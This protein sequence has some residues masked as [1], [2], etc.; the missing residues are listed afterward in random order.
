MSAFLPRSHKA[1]RRE[2]RR[3]WSWRL[4]EIL[5][6]RLEA[7]EFRV[8]PGCLLVAN[9]VSWLDVLVLSALCPAD[10]VAKAE[11]R[12]WPLLGRLLE[13]HDCLF[14]DRRV[15][16]HLLALNV[17][18]AARLA[19]GRVVALF[20]EATTTG[21]ASLLPFRPALF[22]PAVRG[23]HP[24]LAVSL[25]YSD[26]SGRR[27]EAAAFI[28]QQSLWQSL[29]A[30]AVQSAITVQVRDAPP[31]AAAAL[32]RRDAARLAQAAIQDRLR[33]GSS[34]PAPQYPAATPDGAA[35]SA[36]AQGIAPSS[37]API[38]AN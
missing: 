8:P 38:W 15:G 34:L 31:I 22:E 18:I 2:F 20:P 6:I 21:G 29:R 1:R 32:S 26:A 11:I 28:G 10:F 4:L 35:G 14:L 25:V 23:G 27:C 36:S 9:H 17:E 3:R 33:G 7:H 5:G 37:T 12:R 19:A 30:V 16:R 13:R 24:V